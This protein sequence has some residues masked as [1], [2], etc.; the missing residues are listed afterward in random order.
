MINFFGKVSMGGKCNGNEDCVK[1]INT[2][3][4]PFE[5]CVCDHNNIAISENKC[6]PIIGGSCSN[7]NPCYSE[8][9]DCVKNKCQC[10]VGFSS[11]SDSQCVAG[12][13]L[14]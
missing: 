12:N 5:V 3:C 14:T 2:I 7:D 6:S 4:S 8:T 10:K 13:C 11:V 1:L 9:M